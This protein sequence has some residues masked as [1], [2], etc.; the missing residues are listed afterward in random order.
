M[1]AKDKTVD[2]NLFLQA[3]TIAGISVKGKTD[4]EAV[5]AFQGK[6][7][8]QQTGKMDEATTYKMTSVA[9]S[10]G[11]RV[12]YMKPSPANELQLPSRML[13]LNKRGADVPILQNG[14][15][16]LGYRISRAECE[17]QFFGKTTHQAV[18]A[19]Q[20]DR[21]LPQTGRYDSTTR[22]AFVKDI[23][24]V[25]PSV[26]AYNPDQ[27][28]RGTVRNL[29]W[30]P[31]KGVRVEVRYAGEEGFY[32]ER[33][34]NR[35]GFFNIP[36]P[37]PRYAKAG[38]R[39]MPFDIHLSFFNDNEFLW[40]K[41]LRCTGKIS[42]A[43]LT[44]TFPEGRVRDFSGRYLGTS[45]F[46]MIKDLVVSRFGE[47]ILYALC[48]GPVNLSNLSIQRKG[49]SEIQFK[50]MLLAHFIERCA[51]DYVEGLTTAPITAD[52]LY[53]LLR[54][55]LLD[56]CV[57]DP[58]FCY[59]LNKRSG[60]S[61]VTEILPSLMKGLFYRP[62][63]ELH[64]AQQQ[65]DDG[66]VT[67]RESQVNG[68]EVW[69][70]INRLRQVTLLKADILE[71]NGVLSQILECADIPQTKWMSLAEI[72][73][74]TL[75]FND[76]FAD[77]IRSSNLTSKEKNTLLKTVEIGRFVLNKPKLI[78]GVM[79]YFGTASF[80]NVA[81]WGDREWQEI[82][83]GS[84]QKTI[85]AR[86]AKL[87]PEEVYVVG[88]SRLLVGDTVLTMLYNGPIFLD[89]D[90]Q[91]RLSDIGSVNTYHFSDKELENQEIRRSVKELRRLYI[92]SPDPVIGSI[93][94]K[95]K[96]CSAIAIRYRFDRN[97]FVRH[98]CG[99]NADRSSA[100]KAYSNVESQYM[101]V[102]SFYNTYCEETVLKGRQAGKQ[103]NLQNL[104]GS[105]DAYEYDKSMSLLSQSAYLVDLLRFLKSRWADQGGTA[106]DILVSRR[107]DIV[108]LNLEGRNSETVL[109]YID[110]VC[111]LLERKIR[112]WEIGNALD[113][114]RYNT[115]DTS[116]RLLA[117]PA[118]TDK[119]VY[120]RLYLADYPV[121]TSHFSLWQEENRAFMEAL[122]VPRYLL[123][124]EYAGEDELAV[125]A[126]YFGFSAKEIDIFLDHTVY[127]ASDIR[128][129]WALSAMDGPVLVR[130]FMRKTG[131][132]YDETVRLA[133]LFGFTLFG[134]DLADKGYPDVDSQFMTIDTGLEEGLCLMQ[135]FIR[136]W[137]KS[138]WEMERLYDFVK[139]NC[140]KQLDER[141][142]VA[143]YRRIRT[144]CPANQAIG[145]VLGL[146]LQNN[147][148]SVETGGDSPSDPFDLGKIGLSEDILRRWARI[149]SPEEERQ[150][151]A[152]AL[153]CLKLKYG[154]KW[155]EEIRK[156]YDPV[157]EKKRDALVGYILEFSSRNKGRNIPEWKDASDILGDLLVDVMMNAKMETSRIKQAIGSIQLFVQRC[158]LNLE[159]RLHVDAGDLKDTT[160]GN[161]WGQWSW[162]KNYRVWE[163]NRKIFLFPENWTEPELRDNQTP[164]FTEFL[165]TVDQV[166]ATAENL[167]DALLEYLYKLDE[168]SRLEVCSIYR[169]IDKSARLDILHVI[170]RTRSTPT[171]YY[172]RNC[173]LHSEIWSAWEKVD[174]DITGDQLALTLYRGKLYLFWLTFAEKVLKPS[175]MPS[176]KNDAVN[177]AIKYYEIQLAWTLRKK[178]AWT[179]KMTSKL[180]LIHPWPRP[181]YSY[182]L[183]PYMDK[184]GRL[185]LDVYLSTSP[186]FNNLKSNGAE[187]LY[188]EFIC[189][190]SDS[191]HNEHFKPWHSSSFIFE[192]YVSQVFMKNLEH[193]NA[194]SVDFINSWFGEDGRQIKKLPVHYS[195]PSLYLPSG[196]HLK[197]NRLVGNTNLTSP[198]LNVGED[199][200]AYTTRTLLDRVSSPFEL[201]VT[202]QTVQMDALQKGAMLFYQDNYRSY[203]LRTSGRNLYRFRPFYHPFS[204]Q[205]VK[206]LNLKGVDG[207][208]T[209]SMQTLKGPFSF[210]GG[211][212]PTI[213]TDKN[214]PEEKVDFTLTGAYSIYN[215]ELFFH[216]PLTIACRLSQNNRFEDAMKWFHYIFNPVEYTEGQ[217]PQC[218]W[219][220]APFYENSLH[221]ENGTSSGRIETILK[222]LSSNAAQLTAWK[223]NPFKPHIIAQYR[224]ETYQKMVV[225]KYVD[226]LIAWA[227]SLF[228]Q[229]TWE[230]I[231]EAIMLYL[232]AAEILGRKPEK[233]TRDNLP[234]RT[235]TNFLGLVGSLDAFGNQHTQ[236]RPVL[237][238]M[239]AMEDL[240]DV[241]G[242]RD[243]DNGATVSRV[244][245]LDVYYFSV[246]S[247]D[248]LLS[249]WTTVEDRMFKIRNSMNIDGVVRTLSLNAP[250]I[251]PA[252]LVRAA[253]SGLSIEAAVQGVCAERPPY[254][255]RTMLQKAFDLCADVRALGDK[256]LSA[257][258]KEDAA[259]LSQLRA[260]QELRTL[261]SITSLKKMEIMSIEEGLENLN[262][263]RTRA[264]T[265]L[266]FY[267]NIEHLSTKE[268]KVLN[269]ATKSLEA[270]PAIKALESTSAGASMIPSIVAG[271]HGLM[272]T[273]VADSTLFS[274]QM[275]ASSLNF[276]AQILS[277]ENQMAGQKSGILSSKAAYERRSEEWK[278][279]AK[280]AQ[281]DL[282]SIESQIRG[283]EIRLRMAEQ[284]LSNH[285]A[286]I[287]NSNAVFELVKSQFSNRQLYQW[288]KQETVKIF[289]KIY[290]MAYDYAKK[291]EF[292]YAYE[293]GDNAPESVPTIHPD[294]FKDNYKGLLSGEFL[295][296]QLRELEKSYFENDRRCYELTKR[297]SL[298]ELTACGST[299][300]ALV[301]LLRD[302]ACTFDIPE[303]L[304]DLDY[305]THANRRIKN[306]SITIPCVVG[307]NTN[308]NCKLTLLKEQRRSHEN[309]T[310]YD[311]NDVRDA[312][313]ATS[314]AVNDSGMFEVFFHGEKYLP[315]EGYG[316]IS[317]WRI[318]LPAE[319]NH[320]DRSTISD[321]I[322]NITYYAQEG[323]SHTAEPMTFVRVVSLRHEYPSEWHRCSLEGG[324]LQVT[325][326]EN[327][328]QS[329]LRDRLTDGF[330]LTA[331]VK[332]GRPNG[333]LLYEN[334]FGA[335]RKDGLKLTVEGAGR[336]ISE[337]TEDILLVLSCKY[338]K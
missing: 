269:I 275:L 91:L 126:E 115:T 279:Q 170:A 1:A 28:V 307:P 58:C 216:I 131:L 326:G 80:R 318:E 327:C 117:L 148:L 262:V 246:P 259:Q 88:I 335:Y 179:S 248:D 95:E 299:D 271:I 158:M 43:N 182:D 205:Y 24:A 312:S 235:V 207:L 237:D 281:K 114:S 154:E 219:V 201:L 261:E 292:C 56:M 85:E 191:E 129:Q 213:S 238:G 280:T 169:Q 83:A 143:L 33:V 288:L 220:T 249:Y 139:D 160:S 47:S 184:E 27:V 86:I 265:V 331:A 101:R 73:G 183:K 240:A 45:E 54:E 61:L 23:S 316:A 204:A 44:E 163:A 234:Q 123:M 93:L 140:G 121:T 176:G 94:W 130:E 333:N 105:L 89:G 218:Y 173:N 206:T 113:S 214:Y 304:F 59:E 9:A 188:P 39:T 18:L 151:A 75:C 36:F 277:S 310:L 197:A 30:Q 152:E 51:P 317:R 29:N 21:N 111:E 185:H 153:G 253:A 35:K 250:E 225:M 76:A 224:T 177:E 260:E 306:V 320:F 336:M 215:W 321:V 137:R 194:H 287:E 211:Y 74:R 110:L 178:D 294:N 87:Y 14:L 171:V 221:G 37:A 67:L 17:E 254:R 181:Q 52:V 264:E 337:G 66:N 49:F 22:K 12:G 122:G 231:N 172:Y 230:S 267:Q 53:G 82:G 166:D 146:L 116:E 226:N 315:F 57:A 268:A 227:D 15:A 198:K 293:L 127:S 195:G 300:S 62:A 135:R 239:L 222:N 79:D 309:R 274:G 19:Y 284:D 270:F 296:G 6:Y 266:D 334:I 97:S 192:G 305:P 7:H 199:T 81:K 78:K 144:D 175:R 150:T 138:G 203:F 338:P 251:D 50:Q 147:G 186:E 247:N 69:Q 278:L 209:T 2:R 149:G 303:W 289:K 212:L 107:P 302:G 77:S 328:V 136:L 65:A 301:A 141:T 157:R 16:F 92:I 84:D 324:D 10:R 64:S 156:I 159:D 167:E 232:M 282:E 243:G 118:N 258:E 132:T 285:E 308:V 161:S 11:K 68:A 13:S 63:S 5:S 190:Y 109:P 98:V 286:Q 242:F 48:D 313:I 165:D 208:M 255:F 60:Q 25:K 96:L 228:R 168:V 297:I 272:S 108:R 290:E 99:M 100:Q 325:L 245:T 244:P 295:L 40:E 263:M 217:T 3:A 71:D 90:R 102:I 332:Q 72:Y 330:L 257:I 323:G 329:F 322:L 26:S 319:T 46:E 291:A 155:P 41:N 133:R 70:W 236:L 120:T 128:K 189:R 8:L 31:M 187:N 202:Q 104:F 34:T 145:S 252:A 196:M 314:T 210:S 223:N 112:E 125:A 103:A 256:L 180:K 42:W 134:E 276:G 119:D 193:E 241:T 229:D 124:E 20:K 298:A 233:V 283:M 38:G 55:G 311:A 174:V 4:A 164:F 273:P 142:L 162:M 200:A 106:Y 32:A